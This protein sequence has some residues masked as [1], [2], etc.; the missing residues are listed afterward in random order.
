MNQSADVTERTISFI[1]APFV[2]RL[3]GN[4]SAIYLAA[5]V[6]PEA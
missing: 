6:H 2:S 5:G 1:A 3:N 4:T